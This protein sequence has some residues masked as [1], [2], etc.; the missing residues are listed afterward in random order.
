MS[1]GKRLWLALLAVA[2]VLIFCYFRLARAATAEQ[3]ALGHL[4]Q[5]IQA[6]NQEIPELI[7]LL[8]DYAQ[9]RTARRAVIHLAAG[10]TGSEAAL[11]RLPRASL[12]AVWSQLQR[13][14]QQVGRALEE[15]G[16]LDREQK[17]LAGSEVFQRQL[18]IVRQKQGRI[19]PLEQSYRA[20]S[21]HYAALKERI[22]YRWL[23]ALLPYAPP[24]T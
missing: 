20:A 14:E 3:R 12:S 19:A 18:E 13:G 23:T 7:H 24:P 11:G 5:S 6:R 4:I 16:R 17:N 15:V 10:R 9:Q 2:L 21:E 1:S 8:I 22:P